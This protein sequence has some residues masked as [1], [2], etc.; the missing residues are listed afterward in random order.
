MQEVKDRSEVDFYELINANQMSDELWAEAEA[1]AHD[2]MD[3]DWKDY[4]ERKEHFDDAFYTQ[5]PYYFNL[6]KLASN[7]G[8]VYEEVLTKD[9]EVVPSVVMKTKFG[10]AW[11]VKS[12]WDKN[13]DVVE[14]VNVSVASTVEK[15]QK[16]YAKKGY[17]IALVEVRGYIYNGQVKPAW[18]D[19][20]SIEVLK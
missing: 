6:W 10:E 13:A 7:K 19:V 2:A 18:S 14:W 17:Q 8:S 16:H 12:S 4:C 5:S 9:G 15:Q 11:M 20:K 3:K 1:Y